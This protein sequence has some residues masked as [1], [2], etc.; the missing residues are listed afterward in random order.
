MVEPE[1]ETVS[2]VAGQI[3][4][5]NAHCR[6]FQNHTADST[7]GNP[8]AGQVVR[9]KTAAPVAKMVRRNRIFM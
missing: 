9:K 1:L 5:T 6:Y 4:M 7:L 8:H 3:R 2:P